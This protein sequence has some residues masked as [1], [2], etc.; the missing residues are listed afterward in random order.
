[1]TASQTPTSAHP[2]F[3]RAR[4]LTQAQ[5][6]AV[7]LVLT[8]ATDSH[9]ADT[10]GLNRSTITRWRLYDPYFKAELIA[11]RRERFAGAADSLR[12][13]IPMALDTLRDQLRVGAGRGTIA[14]NF[15]HKTGLI[16]AMTEASVS[17]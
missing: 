2:T 11:R 7:D 5:H 16:A 14:L 4:G 3:K 12:G 9:I 13:V 6:E 8:G 1:M 15:L 17:A 10:I